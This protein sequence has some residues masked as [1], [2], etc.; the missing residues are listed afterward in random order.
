MIL[1]GRYQSPFVRRVGIALHLHDLPFDHW[2]GSVFSDAVRPV[3]H[4]F[5][6]PA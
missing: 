1:I 2:P 3:R 6:A 5:L 4:P